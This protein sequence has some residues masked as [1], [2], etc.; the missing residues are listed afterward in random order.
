M[1]TLP[2]I[3]K[4]SLR[5]SETHRPSVGSRCFFSHAYKLLQDEFVPK[6]RLFDRPELR[7]GALVSVLKNRSHIVEVM[8]DGATTKDFVSPEFLLSMDLTSF[9]KEIAES[10]GSSGESMLGALHEINK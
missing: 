1:K 3:F 4:Q 5:Y 6:A 9:G 8:F 2:H 7:Q 10:L